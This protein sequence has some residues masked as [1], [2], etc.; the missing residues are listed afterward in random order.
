MVQMADK[1]V[2]HISP[3]DSTLLSIG[4]HVLG[5]IA[6]KIPMC[7]ADVGS[8]ERIIH[9]SWHFILVSVRTSI[10]TVHAP[11]DSSA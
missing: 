2:F 3:I 10:A 11:I 7:L 6:S 9:H 1:L 8:S 4:V 5:V